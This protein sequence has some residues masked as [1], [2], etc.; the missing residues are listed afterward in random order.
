VPAERD[1]VG[2]KIDYPGLTYAPINEQGVVLLFGTMSDELGFSVEAIRS[3][4]PDALVVD[5][6]ANP[7]RGVK[8]YIEFEFK[9]SHFARQ[10]GHDP[11]KCDI[12]VC[13]EHDWQH[14][15]PGIEIIE[16]RN[17]IQNLKQAEQATIEGSF[18]IPKGAIRVPTYAY[19]T[20][21]YAG[22]TTAGTELL[23]PKKE[24]PDYETSWEARL[25][26][27][28][29]ATRELVQLFIARLLHEIPSLAGRARFRWYSIYRSMPP[30][31]K[32]DVATLLIGR[33]NVKLSI[34]INPKSFSDPY[35]ISKPMAGFFY[36]R[37]TERRMPVTGE[38]LETVVELAKS[39][40]QGLLTQ[41]TD[42]PK[43]RA[44]T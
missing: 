18:A 37:G 39:A 40:Y 8:K 11:K 24:K 33:K 27:V 22:T 13:W 25:D 1:E 30:V 12:I 44:N 5:Y 29:P 9:S 19:V 43:A 38:N 26:W 21:G 14:L 23:T 20:T 35:K 6:R 28:E 2:A 7:N 41:G 10:K 16:L 32:N 4:F 17:L 34:R 15:P 31:R 3:A 42:E 36:P